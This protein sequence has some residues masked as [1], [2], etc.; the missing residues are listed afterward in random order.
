MEINSLMEKLFRHSIEIFKD[1]YGHPMYEMFKDYFKTH[2]SIIVTGA[3]T[4][5]ISS[6]DKST[7]FPTKYCVMD[8]SNPFFGEQPSWNSVEDT[9]KIVFCYAK[10]DDG[11]LLLIKTIVHNVLD[12]PYNAQIIIDVGKLRYHRGTIGEAL[13]YVVYLIGHDLFECNIKLI[14]HAE[15][16]FNVDQSMFISLYE[17]LY[18]SMLVGCYNVYQIADPIFSSGF[19]QINDI[20]LKELFNVRKRL[21]I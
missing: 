20:L 12:E 3:Y 17:L 6:L 1:D 4:F 19:F 21:G 16:I 8:Q 11:G 9:Y 10:A 15:S 13:Q 7:G 14:H 5:D 2:S 18:A